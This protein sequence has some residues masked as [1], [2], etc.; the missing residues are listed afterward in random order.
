M[1]SADMNRCVA[2]PRVATCDDRK[3]IVKTMSALIVRI[4]ESETEDSPS[5][6][7]IVACQQKPQ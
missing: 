6:L 5:G 1:W 7:I 3:E 4:N 2:C